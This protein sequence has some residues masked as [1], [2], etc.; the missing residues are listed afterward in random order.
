MRMPG[1]H[2]PSSRVDKGTRLSQSQ[3]ECQGRGRPGV[4][5]V[6]RK[7]D[8]LA[9]SARGLWSVFSCALDLAVARAQTQHVSPLAGLV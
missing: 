8:K 1:M 9:D 6:G 3:L 2:L 5:V 4:G 7:I